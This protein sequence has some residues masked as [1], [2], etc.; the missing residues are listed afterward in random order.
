MNTLLPEKV[1]TKIT[2]TET[3]GT[4]FHN[5]GSAVVYAQGTT[6]PVG[7]DSTTAVTGKTA[8]GEDVAFFGLEV[9][10]FIYAYALTG[11]ARVTVS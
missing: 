10:E 4:V 2:T 9:G 3:Q 7:F 8:L 5:N 1:W 11:D 6:A